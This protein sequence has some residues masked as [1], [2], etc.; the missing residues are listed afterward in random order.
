MKAKSIKGATP[1]E[2]RRA[3]SEA[4]ADGF[5]P[6]LAT[7]FMS[8]QQDRPAICRLMDEHGIAVFGATTG[9]EFIDGDLGAGTI[10]ILLMDLD[11]AYFRI[12][13]ED[14]EGKDATM[15]AAEMTRAGMRAFA[16]P[17]FILSHG[18]HLDKDL[19]LSENIIEAINHVAGPE[20]E[21]WGGAAGDDFAYKTTF[22]FDNHRAFD[23][24]ILMLVLDTDHVLVKGHSTTGN[25]AVGTEKT[26]TRSKDNWVYT[27]DD[28]PA[29]DIVLKY[30][31]ID[32]TP[33]ELETFNPGVIVLSVSRERG[34]PIF[35][36]SAWFNW[37]DKSIAV[38]SGIKEGDKIRLTLP[39]D[40]DTIDE[41]ARQARAVQQREMPE[42]DALLMFSC[43]G[44]LGAFGPLTGEEVA[45]VKDVFGAPMAG[46]FTY[47]EFGRATN[48]NN[49][50]HNMTCCWVALKEK[51]AGE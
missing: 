1:E 25:K 51:R 30:L 35:R 13:L 38:T 33:E 21:V 14:Y 26:I 18:F 36:S 11:P 39:P 31:G 23:Q 19:S 8:I 20:T 42:A 24:G 44:R 32:L 22:V 46:F 12:L 27:I 16:R 4:K 10:A 9:G 2:I 28:Q 40:F 3:L 45:G 37:R 6:T 50:L 47:G 5:N 43:I 29:A 34:E 48:G 17:A 49:E 15:V 41:A 7:V